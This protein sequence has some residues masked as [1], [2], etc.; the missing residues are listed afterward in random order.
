MKKLILVG[1]LLSSVLM[2]NRYP[3]ILEYDFMASCMNN[4]KNIK[5]DIREDYCSCSLKTMENKYTINEVTKKLSNPKEQKIVINYITKKC[6][7]II[8]KDIK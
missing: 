4:A 3:I 5:Y 8:K 2:A 7:Y 1:V 6:I